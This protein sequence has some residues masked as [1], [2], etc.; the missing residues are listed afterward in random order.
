LRA[1]V[2]P[3]RYREGSSKDFIARLDDP[4]TGAQIR[5]DVEKALGGRD[6]GKRIQIA[7][8]SKNRKWQG[9]NIAQIAE[10]E[11][12]QPVDIAL[13]IERNGGAQ[14]VNFSMSEEDVRIYMKR[15]WVATA[16]DGGVQTPGDTV[17]HPRNY[18][19]FP[20]KIGRYALA[21]GILPLEQAIRASSG[22]P[23][24]IL[25]LTNRGYLKPGA[26]ADVVVF[27]PKTFRDTAT[28]AK[29][30]QY[31]A[32]VKWV[33]VNGT[34]VVADGKHDPKALPGRVLRHSDSAR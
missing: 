20:R 1:T 3:S 28:F 21:D 11:G 26:F 9:K 34:P 30:H 7:R 10:T 14:V 6:G 22:L 24:D 19:T 16:S 13:E 27:D 2:I 4:K 8:Y 31:A 29:P 15:P 32:G 23:A 18:G 12:K 17:P 25:K 5:K 33:F